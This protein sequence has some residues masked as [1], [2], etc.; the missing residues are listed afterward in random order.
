MSTR[1]TIEFKADGESIFV[2]RHC[3]GFPDVIIPDI[4]AAIEKARGRWSEPEPGILVT[5]FLA[6]HYDPD[7]SRLPDYWV[8]TGV[9]GDESYLYRVV[10]DD[11]KEA[12]EVITT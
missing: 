2:Y 8:S 12:W 6:M 7:K 10:W 11:E 1:A 3:D 5:M 9:A 4:E